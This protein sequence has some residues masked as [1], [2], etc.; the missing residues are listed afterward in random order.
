[1]A[2]A[3]AGARRGRHGTCGAA[4]GAAASGCSTECSGRTGAAAQPALRL[5]E[6]TADARATY[7]RAIAAQKAGDWAKYG[8]EIQRL[9]EILQRMRQ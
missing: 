8:E 7:D 2:G 6:L 4:A 1:M 9:G 3:R 5:A